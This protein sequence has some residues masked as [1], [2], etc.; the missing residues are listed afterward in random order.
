MVIFF[1]EKNCFNNRVDRDNEYFGLT[2]LFSFGNKI[3]LTYWNMNNYYI[4]Y[5]NMFEKELNLKQIVV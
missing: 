5:S 4:T 3:F 2:N 1:Y